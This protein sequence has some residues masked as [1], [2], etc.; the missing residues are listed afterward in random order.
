MKSFA[1]VG[2]KIALFVE[3]VALSILIGGCHARVNL[4][5]AFPKETTK[6]DVQHDVQIEFAG[7][8]T[9]ALTRAALNEEELSAGNKL[10][11][12]K[13]LRIV[14]YSLNENSKPD[15]ARFVF[16][17]T[18]EI[19]RGEA[20]GVD[21]KDFS[22]EKRTLKLKGSEIIPMGS[23][24][25]VYFTSPS[26]S[27]KAATEKG[28]HFNELMKAIVLD[29]FRGQGM[30]Q[31]SI[32]SNV[33]DPLYIRE[34][35]LR[36][37]GSAKP[38]EIAPLNL[39]ALN[40][41]LYVSADPI[42]DDKRFYIP[43][44]RLFSVWLNAANKTLIPIPVT[45]KI[46]ITGNKEVFLPKDNNYNTSSLSDEGLREQLWY[47][48]EKGKEMLNYYTF[49]GASKV[50]KRA[51]WAMAVPENT[52]SHLSLDSR[53]VTQ[54]VLQIPIYPKSLVEKVREGD[55]D[56]MLDSWLSTA[57]GES[58]L[59][60]DFKTAYDSARTTSEAKRTKEQKEIFVIG[61]ELTAASKGTTVESLSGEEPLNAPEFCYSSP[62][63]Q[64]HHKGMTYFSI[65]IRHFDDSAQPDPNVDGRY[66]VVRNTLYYYHIKAFSGVGATVFDKIDNGVRKYDKELNLSS[67]TSVIALPEIIIR[68]VNL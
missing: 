3:T 9:S 22:F 27:L 39:K 67:G 45:E 64:F 10:I 24:A 49:S 63:V 19:F 5:D 35:T 30:L 34:E 25:V 31:Y 62:N 12:L 1:T 44:N 40:G 20:T 55:K 16:D 8:L 50:E 32:Y 28:K 68:E 14:L 7:R 51:N 57:S 66:G 37:N 15:V 58:Y 53:T 17:R 46:T 13:D 43:K 4:D 38:Y 23:Y 41:L 54:L 21:L 6:K 33:D 60:E 18:F 47:H 48:K 56:S 65:P 2:T 26:V 59:F 36:T 61:R 11:A 29:D 42:V 52:V